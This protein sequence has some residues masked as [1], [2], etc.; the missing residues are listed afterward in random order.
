MLPNSTWS[1]AESGLVSNPMSRHAG[2][3]V[4][5]KQLHSA[6]SP[7][8]HQ[9]LELRHSLTMLSHPLL[10]FAEQSHDPYTSFQ[11]NARFAPAVDL[12]FYSRRSLLL[13]PTHNQP[14]YFT[15]LHSVILAV[16]GSYLTDSSLT[17]HR[18]PQ[19][20]TPFGHHRCAVWIYLTYTRSPPLSLPF[21]FDCLPFS[22]F[23]PSPF[24]SVAPLGTPE[25]QAKNWSPNSV[26][27]IC[28]AGPKCQN[29]HFPDLPCPPREPQ[30]NHF[31]DFFHFFIIL[32]FLVHI[33][34]LSFLF[35]CISFLCSYFYI[36]FYQFFVSFCR[37]FWPQFWAVFRTPREV[38]VWARAWENTAS[39]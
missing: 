11:C 37:G 22:S 27:I 4:H 6:P 29:R 28:D 18:K 19:T 30:K 8:H 33:F 36:I 7:L 38:V 2:S 20:L 5:A 16:P 23:P 13:E 21:W 14:F 26:L 12:E 1:C 9:I 34:F 3:H 15:P 17:P 39:V 32:H 10:V 35:L 24:P 31:F 25:K